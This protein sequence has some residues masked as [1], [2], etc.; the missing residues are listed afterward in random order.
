[1]KN[2][3]EGVSRVCEEWQMIQLQDWTKM[4]IWLWKWGICLSCNGLEISCGQRE[5]S[6]YANIAQVDYVLI[7]LKQAL[8]DVKHLKMRWRLVL[9]PRPH[10]G[11]LRRSP[12][13]LIA[14]NFAPLAL[15]LGC[16]RHPRSSPT[17][18]IVRP[19]SIILWPGYA[20]V[21]MKVWRRHW[22]IPVEV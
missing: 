3:V 16:L 8:F 9:R 4:R 21:T 1:M 15:A 12:D 10:W 17:Y 14:R 11:S 20:L 7:S 18:C 5:T 6:G 2:C 22:Q 19:G 13:P